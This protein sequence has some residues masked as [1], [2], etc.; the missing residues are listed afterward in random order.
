MTRWLITRTRESLAD[1]L[2]LVLS[3]A[4]LPGVSLTLT[5][6]VVAVAV[7]EAPLGISMEGAAILARRKSNDSEELTGTEQAV[8]FLFVFAC[9]WIVVGLPIAEIVTPGFD[10]DGFWSWVG[11]ILFVAGLWVIVPWQARIRRL[12]AMRE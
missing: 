8:V 5:G 11:S 1:A 6:L 2:A 7:M 9:L 4:L 12:R 10:I 3:A